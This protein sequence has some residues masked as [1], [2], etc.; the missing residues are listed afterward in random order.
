M[1][2]TFE[3]RSGVLAIGDPTMGMARYSVSLS[4]GLY[5]LMPKCLQPAPASV[6]TEP[7]RL[8]NLDSPCIF[9]MEYSYLDDFE[10]WYHHV[11]AGCSYM[12]MTIIDQLQDFESSI[13][14]RVAQYWEA[15]LAVGN[16]EGTYVL[17]PSL[18]KESA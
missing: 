12:L 16:R 4:P 11:G 7:H 8:I 14:S 18:I 3:I 2:T 6:P 5:R 9:A 13:G 10:A 15:D 17:D 1:G